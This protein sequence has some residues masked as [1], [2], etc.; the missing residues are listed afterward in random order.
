V[1]FGG[2]RNL[3]VFKRADFPILDSPLPAGRLP[4]V[5][6][7]RAAGFAREETR[8]LHKNG[9]GCGTREINAPWNLACWPRDYFSF[10]I[11][12]GLAT[13]GFA[14]SILHGCEYSS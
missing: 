11:F 8:T 9:K 7:S 14:I 12:A 2:C 5:F 13:R 10:A 1:D 3:A 6:S 4:S